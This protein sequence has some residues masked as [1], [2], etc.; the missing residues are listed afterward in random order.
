MALPLHYSLQDVVRY[1]EDKLA[2]LSYE[3]G[4][5]RADIDLLKEIKP[6]K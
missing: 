4:K 1:F 3:L 6:K 5:M 2:K